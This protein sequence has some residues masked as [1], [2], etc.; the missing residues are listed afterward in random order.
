MVV[1]A[2]GKTLFVTSQCEV[3]SRFHVLAKFVDTTCILSHK[4]KMKSTQQVLVTLQ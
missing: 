3:Y 4:H 1:I 2:T